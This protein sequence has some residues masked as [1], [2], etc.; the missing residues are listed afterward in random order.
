MKKLTQKCK[1]CGNVELSF[2]CDGCMSEFCDNCLSEDE[3]EEGLGST[4]CYHLIHP[5]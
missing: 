1:I 4:F 3:V 5:Y 2:Y